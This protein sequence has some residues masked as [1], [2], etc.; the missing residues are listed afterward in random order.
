[1][2]LDTSFIT[3]GGASTDSTPAPET[4]EV[5]TPE[6]ASPAPQD[7]ANATAV[8]EAPSEPGSTSEPAPAE[9]AAPAEAPV[10]EDGKP[11][12][13]EEIEKALADERTPKFFREQLKKFQAYSSKLTAE[14][15]QIETE[16]TD[17]RSRYE[18][19]EPLAQTD[20]ER[21]RAAE[22]RQYKLSSF[23]ASPEEVLST[24][25]E[26]VTPQK[27]AEIKNH[28]AWEFLEDAN[29]QPDLEN[30]Q[31]IIDKF[32]GFKEGDTRV[33]AKDVLNAIQAL[34]RGTVKPEE[35]HEFTSDVE[36]EAFQR[37]RAVESEIEAQRQLAADN[38]KF[39][40]SQTRVSVLQN[41]LT[42]IQSQFRPQVET[43]LDKFQLNSV[44]NEPKVA[45]EFKQQIRERIAQEVNTVSAKNPSLADVFK[46]I[47]LLSKPTGRTAE[48]VRQEI[49]GY[50]SSFPY[51]T[52]VSRGL[53]EL[54]TSVE[55]VVAQEAYRYKLL[56]KGYEQEV[57]K[58]QHAREV[59]GQPKQ[60]E[61]L[62]QYTPEQLASM[63]AA[64]RRHALLTQVSNQ[65]RDAGKTPRYGG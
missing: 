34:K 2:E 54:M 23:T 49:E 35:L 26:T 57:T 28:L 10:D 16:L 63:S 41:V 33:G 61:V 60:T 30:L 14:R 40:E 1:M 12:S 22:E 9:P 56:M 18:G 53:S 47:D 58:G 46:A 43:L 7:P 52:A 4:I 42:G 44:P 32:S 13:D 17:F 59:I 31:V 50:V 24:L 29:G 19:K 20:L 51:Q 36:Y 65:L 45:V 37:A 27:M 62:T 5:T 48:Q 55:K 64:E 8:V 39:Q 21:L 11:M 3:E 15:Q 38:A 6:I 25:K